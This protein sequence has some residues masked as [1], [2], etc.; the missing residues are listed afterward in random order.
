MNEDY[1]V[2]KWKV[3]ICSIPDPQVRSRF[4]GQFRINRIRRWEA[5]RRAGRVINVISQA[6]LLSG[7]KW[8]I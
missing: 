5:A 7:R 3:K 4:E 2:E 6:G 8:A 1:D